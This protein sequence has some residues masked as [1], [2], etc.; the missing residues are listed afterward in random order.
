MKY[1]SDTIAQ[2]IKRLN[3]NYFLPAI[4]REY[5][6]HQDQIIALFDSLMRGYPISTFLFWELEPE[7]YAKWEIYKFVDNFNQAGTH[8]EPANIHGVQ[9]LTLVLDGQQRLTSF[10][11]GLKGTYTVKKKYASGHD[12]KAWI[13]Q[14]FYLDLLHDSA[15][16]DQT[17]EDIHYRFRFIDATT[18]PN[19][20]DKQFWFEVG[21]I[22]NF[23]SAKQFDDFLDQKLDSLPGTVMKKQEKTFEKNLRRLYS[24]IWDQDYIAYYTEHDQD[25]DRVLTIFVRANQGGTPLSKSD[26]LLSMMT[27]KWEG[28][29]ARDEIYEFVEHLN[30]NLTRK[31]NVDKD[32]IMKTC[33][34]LSD[35]LIQYKVEN[36]KNENLE[37]IHTKWQAIKKAIEAAIN[38]INSFGI[39]RDNL[40]SANALIPIIY[41]IYTHP[42]INFFA[43][44]PF[45]VDNT[46]RIRNWFLLA[47]L[48]N[49]FSGQSDRALTDTRKVL[50]DAGS[51]PA[52]P[53]DAIN[54]EL[55]RTNRKASFDEE[56][57]ETILALTY[58]K[59]LTVLVLSLLLED[60]HQGFLSFHQDHI[61]P[62]DH[63]KPQYM[64]NAGLSYDQQQ[65]YKEMMNRLGNLQLLS[66][67]ENLEKSNQDFITWL[68][69]RDTNFRKKYLIPD[70]NSLLAFDRFPEFMSAREELIRQR[71]KQI[72]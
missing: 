58:S 19:N 5:V 68:A 60:N 14:K 7:N 59:P 70:D 37:L 64:K 41:Y 29:N 2:I 9:Q 25:F 62:Q 33:L 24:T 50:L 32:F 66:S 3:G 1:Q 57:V 16:E 21:Q 56:T 10:L 46:S 67:A 48:N 36:F 52:F 49:T 20:D 65:Q 4:Q 18:V 43:N 42:K 6:W 22:L 72:F 71:L 23:T 12:P 31:N 35:L 55:R 38:L 51:S 11:I 44:T 61:F 30:K 63:F 27:A 8:N 13:K 26:L 39:D 17:E 45:D 34:V 53:A 15:N 54:R 69:T 28:N 47:L 40:T